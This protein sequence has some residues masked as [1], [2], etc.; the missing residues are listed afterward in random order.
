LTFND[1][2]SDDQVDS[3]KEEE[4]ADIRDAAKVS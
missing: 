2:E 3:D 4:I 1:V